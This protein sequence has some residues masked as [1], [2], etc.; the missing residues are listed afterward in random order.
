MLPRPPHSQPIVVALLLL[1]ASGPS[2]TAQTAPTV[3]DAGP[4]PMPVITPEEREAARQR[5]RGNDGVIEFDLRS[6]IERR[7]AKAPVPAV[8]VDHLEA[9]DGAGM[10]PGEAEKNF[11]GYYLVSNP[12]ISLYPRH[13]KV[14]I[15][16]QRVDGQMVGGACSGT[17]IGPSHVI[18]AGHC[19]YTHDPDADGVEREPWAVQVKVAPG[20]ND[21]VNGPAG[22]AFATNIH[23]WT[24]WTDDE[25]WDHDIAVL[26]LNRA[27]GAIVGWRGVGASSSWSFFD[28]STWET[29]TYPGNDYWEEQ[30]L[31]ARFM[32]YQGGDYDYD[33]A[34]TY[35]MDRP[36]FRGTSGGGAI[37]NNAVWAIRSHMIAYVND[38][39]TYD[40]AITSSKLNSISTWLTSDF[41]AVSDLVPLDVRA[42]SDEVSVGGAL[43]GVDFIVYNRSSVAHTAGT[44]Y[45][46]YLGNNPVTTTSDT[47]VFDGY[48][49]TEIG[50]GDFLRLTVPDLV[51]P[52]QLQAGEYYLGVFLTG[53]DYNYGNNMTREQDT[54]PLSVICAAQGTPQPALPV[55]GHP[56]VPTDITLDWVEVPGAGV[57]YEIDLDKGLPSG[58][59]PY[60]STNIGQHTFY[61]L[62]ADSWYT[63]RVRAVT[64]CGGPGNWSQIFSFRTKGF[65]QDVSLLDP[66]PATKCTGSSVTMSWDAVP[67]ASLYRLRLQNT[68]TGGL[69]IFD[70]TD[71]EL[72]VSGLDPNTKYLWSVKWRDAC[73]E[74]GEYG[75]R[76]DF[77][78]TATALL[79]AAPLQPI[80]GAFTGLSPVFRVQDEPAAFEYHY[81]LET[82]AGVPVAT[83]QGP[84]VTTPS[85][86]SGGD[87]RW[88][89]R[90]VTCL[91]A[92]GL[93]SGDWSA[94]QNFSVDDSP[95]IF[96]FPPDPISPQPGV[97]TNNPLVSVQWQAASD[98]SGVAAYWLAWDQSTDTVPDDS[99]STP[100]A[101]NWVQTLPEGQNWFHL[102]AV[103]LHGNVSAPQHLGPF[104]IDV[105]G[106]SAPQPTANIEPLTWTN[107]DDIQV[108]WPACVDAGSG[109]AGYSFA[110][111]TSPS[112]VL[113]SSVDT[114][115]LTTSLAPAPEGG[116]FFYIR[117]VDQVGY[118]GAITSVRY[119]VDR[120]APTGSIQ[121]PNG[122]EVLLQ[123]STY[124]VQF[125]AN[126]NVAGQQ[127]ILF[128]FSYSAN[129]GSSWYE[130]PCGTTGTMGECQIP[131]GGSR[132]FDWLVPWAPP[133]SPMLFR[134]VM[135]DP[136]G[137]TRELVSENPFTIS[138][139]TDADALPEIR[140]FA[141]LG[142]APN[143]FNP[144]TS[145][146]YAI[147][148]DAKVQLEIFDLSGRL[149]RTLVDE[150]Q[151][152]PQR[153]D[154]M[155]DGIDAQGRR[156]AS[157]TYIYRLRAGEFEQ[158]R[159][160]TLLK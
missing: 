113:D 97:W 151:R 73:L 105:V 17:L 57:S 99:I 35:G 8:P 127:Q 15:T 28:S 138:V 158:A 43:S 142:N 137:N 33:Y 106:P 89:A 145:I 21:G 3:R 45:S 12:T 74:W 16:W 13:V 70:T 22:D 154:V 107:V 121:Q 60:T 42:E 120:T 128:A 86:L 136:A 132:S 103:D 160:M 100:N 61:G 52:P 156:V 130:I 77:S 109:V 108:S 44:Q 20:W 29:F 41:P 140:D 139:A 131:G 93:V 59:G 71:T 67:T 90:I 75:A 104:L 11:S 34:P 116:R 88:R 83:W 84:W 50:P 149:I 72:L 32:Y 95:P 92:G 98:E 155:W 24:G 110:W 119:L 27:V 9:G 68:E 112:Y 152:G 117:A 91:N 78:T 135:R 111:S 96:L 87:Y 118:A 134:I 1:I 10:L 53:Q 124:Q 69:Q 49:P 133:G 4:E 47:Y 79:S 30:D 129:D 2:L 143:P 150:S 40:V 55:D 46:V 76:S 56:C 38:V 126:E 80:G 26:T 36:G 159:R 101:G 157:G 19:V 115:N 66:E 7:Y 102:V 14:L 37:K 64:S 114:T 125:E 122:G 58:A 18:T 123:G 144:R 94:W 153:Y 147:P 25:D 82:A 146:E 81:E 39:D 23:T 31:T 62:D 148:T 48:L 85:P 54:L 65:L 141:L 6:S 5:S 63:W 51:V